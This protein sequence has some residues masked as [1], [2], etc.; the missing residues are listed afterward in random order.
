MQVFDSVGAA[1][2]LALKIVEAQPA[3]KQKPGLPQLLRAHAELRDHLNS[4]G[5]LMAHHNIE[6]VVTISAGKLEDKADVRAT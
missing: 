6:I 3:E 1:L 4:Y 5:L 2:D